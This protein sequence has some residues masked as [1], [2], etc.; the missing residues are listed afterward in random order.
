MDSLVL[1]TSECKKSLSLALL[2]QSF[3]IPSLAAAASPNDVMILKARVCYFL[4]S[5]DYPMRPSEVMGSIGQSTM[6]GLSFPDKL[7]C[8]ASNKMYM[9]MQVRIEH[10]RLQ[11]EG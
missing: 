11:Q 6:L 7:R 8:K 5:D 3:A 1:G 9:L 2:I 4:L 10:V